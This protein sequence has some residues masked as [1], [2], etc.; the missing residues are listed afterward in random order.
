M[1]NP[2]EVWG[3]EFIWMVHTFERLGA[4]FPHVTTETVEKALE[5]FPEPLAEGRDMGTLAAAI[6]SFLGR[7]VK[8]AK[9]D[10]F[11]SQGNAQTRDNL[12]KLADRATALWQD[13]AEMPRAE[14]SAIRA[15]GL[16]RHEL[17]ISSGR[18]DELN[19][20][21]AL[22][23]IYWLSDFLTGAALH[24]NSGDNV[25]PP[26]WRERAQRETRIER[27]VAMAQ[28]FKAAFALPL[29]VNNWPSG[30]DK[31]PTLFM[32]FYRRIITLALNG[33]EADTDISGVLRVARDREAERERKDW[34]SRHSE[35]SAVAPLSPDFPMFNAAPDDHD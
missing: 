31:A 13:L 15:H 19:Y 27:G 3:D 14:W 30:K 22:R 28:V 6:R 20:M 16:E 1:N 18:D 8:P 23:H 7:T 24:M 21:L 29:T 11:G 9:D 25:Q 12:Y 33:Q 35:P 2:A 34:A 26:R 10:P 17:R 32:E 4:S 5:G